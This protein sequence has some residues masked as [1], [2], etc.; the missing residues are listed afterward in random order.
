MK[1]IH[2]IL[3]ILIGSSFSTFANPIKTDTLTIENKHLRVKIS[4]LGAEIISIYNKDQHL[5]HIWKGEKASWN[6]HAPILF[7]I[8]GKLKNKQYQLDGKTYKMKNHGFASHRKFKLFKKTRNKVTLQL[9]SD[10]VSLKIYPY[11]FV[12]QATYQLKGTQ[13]C[14]HYTV[15][16][17]DN[18]DLFFSI[19]AHPGFSI[20]L[21]ANETYNDYYIEFQKKETHIS[22]L[23]LTPKGFLSHTQKTNY[24]NNS[25]KIALSH[26]LFKDRV[27]IL[28][29][30][31][32]KWLKIKSDNAK[33]AL[34]IGI[35]NFNFV[36]LWTS[37]KKDAPFVC[38]E[39]W[40]G[41]TDYS[42]TTGNLKVK[43]GI[44]KLKSGKKFDMRYYIK[45][46]K[47][48]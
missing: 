5:E 44:Q 13:V 48:K 2:F 9:Q 17:T 36:G 46:I 24:T 29:G 11:Q 23:P 26:Q 18:K 35:K 31:T 45:I 7:P 32:S 10:E 37:H 14:I 34:K 42:D 47:N 15:K 27:V 22:R 6:Q 30:I 20:P 41:I 40:H 8:V 28:D 4:T 21:Q 33:I 25:N 1:K 3:L 38:V 16:N 43:K 12:L 19:G 39:P